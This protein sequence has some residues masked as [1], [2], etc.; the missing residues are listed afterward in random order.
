M[1]WSLYKKEWQESLFRFSLSLA[2]LTAAYVFIYIFMERETPLVFA[3][4]LAVVFLHIFY[5]F[6]MLLASLIKEW[7]E[8][9]SHLWMNL[10]VKGYVL[11]S[12]KLAAAFTQFLISISYAIVAAD[13]ILQRA[14]RMFEDSAAEGLTGIISM[15]VPL[16]RELI[17]WVLLAV[18]NGA[19]QLGIAAMFIFIFSKVVRPFGWLAAI[20]LT[21][22]ANYIYTWI[23]NIPLIERSTEWLPLLKG[24]EIY[25]KIYAL[26]PG[27][28]DLMEVSEG[29]MTNVYL[30]QIAAELLVLTGAFFLISWLL[31][32]K[33]EL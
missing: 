24:E 23:K 29:I 2:L 1:W 32:R 16:Y 30:G 26:Y 27:G 13:L 4:S 31:D 7:K 28:A 5:L 3:V 19:L 14:M 20:V 12:A 25:K 6:I 8:N 11:L 21:I 17:P 22:L 18:T 15:L 9:T 33:V 10:P